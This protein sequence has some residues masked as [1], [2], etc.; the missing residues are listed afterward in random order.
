M[1]FR[2]RYVSLAN[3]LRDHLSLENKEKLKMLDKGY[4]KFVENEK[5]LQKLRKEK[6]D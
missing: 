2:G 3:K 4:R 1:I 5:Y 6:N